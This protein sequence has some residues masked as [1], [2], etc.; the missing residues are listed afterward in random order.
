MTYICTSNNK[1]HIA[2]TSIKFISIFLTVTLLASC[3]AFRKKPLE[4]FQEAQ[5][6]PAY[7]AI[8]VPGNPHDG[9]DWNATMNCRVSWSVFLYEKGITKNI[10]FSG[11]SVYSKYV[12]AK[13]MKEYAIAL[14]VPA[15]HIFLDTNAEHSTENVYYSY[16]VAKE[17]G[18]ERIALTTD[19][20]QSKML[21]RFMKKHELP[22]D[23]L[24]VVFDSIGPPTGEVPVI[25]ASVAINNSFVSI[26]EREGFF[27]RL[28]GTRGLNIV[29]NEE[30]L[31][32][33]KLISKYE[34]RGKLN[35][36]PTNAQVSNSNP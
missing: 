33:K 24:T 31:P 29:W 10:I 7:D 3:G 21:K 2:M 34:S 5:N 26:K 13:V 6:A 32:N 25:D 4:R 11:S 14:G 8:I 19:P 23:N 35:R 12:E 15:E 16:K 28:R 1:R 17:Q 36:T 20:F 22:I 9:Q 30:D 18:F 27:K